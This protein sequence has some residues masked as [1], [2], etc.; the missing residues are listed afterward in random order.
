MHLATPSSKQGDRQFCPTQLITFNEVCNLLRKSR[1]GIYKLMSD[2]P[3]FPRSL[4]SSHSRSARAFFIAEEIAVW[5]QAKV[6]ARD[7]R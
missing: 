3:T 2:D 1:S 4:K 6:S 5:Q 7:K